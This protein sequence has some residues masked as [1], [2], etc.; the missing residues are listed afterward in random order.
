[1]AGI[2]NAGATIDM[3]RNAQV[4]GNRADGS[5][6]GSEGGGIFNGFDGT[7]TMSG[8]T[9]VNRNTALYGAGI[10]NVGALTM[11]GQAQA[12]ANTATGNGGGSTTSAPL[13]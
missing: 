3:T 12:N 2:W 10:N 11:S 5:E 4:N 7:L 8:K 6:G 1:M 13:P 9:Q